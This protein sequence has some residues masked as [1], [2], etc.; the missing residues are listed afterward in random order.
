MQL[1]NQQ[2]L[3]ALSRVELNNLREFIY[4][5]DVTHSDLLSLRLIV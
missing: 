5:A 4:G 2:G 1:P 3:I